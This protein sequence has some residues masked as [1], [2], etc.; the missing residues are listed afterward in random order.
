MIEFLEADI[1]NILALFLF[2]V[3]CIL[4][5]KNGYREKVRKILFFLVCR[6]EDT[7]G[8]K[9][10]TLKYAAVTTWLYEKLPSLIK[11]IFSQNE[12]DRMLE[13]AVEEMK[14]YLSEIRADN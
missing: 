6:A 14:K 10:G 7:Y 9:T 11:L 3:A 13:Q 8:S 12:I 4:L 2:A 1:G 5:I